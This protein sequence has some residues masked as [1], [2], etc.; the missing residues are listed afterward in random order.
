MINTL[1]GTIK[2]ISDN[3][4][5]LE[6][7]SIGFAIQVP[8]TSLFGIGQPAHLLI[9][10]HWNQENGPAL[11]GFNSSLEK[12]VFLLIT[13]CSGVGPKLGMAILAQLG[14]SEFLEAVQSANEGALSAVSGIGAKKAEQIIVHLKHKVAKL[15]ESGISLGGSATLEQ[16]HNISQV[17]KS[18]NYSR[19]EISAAMNYLNDSYPSNSVAF[20][21]L[22]RHALSFLAKRT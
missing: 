14:A 11:F 2:D 15:V 19:Q 7:G 17:L 13:S 5:T 20:D 6:A 1:S 9:H 10:M 18:L 4:L 3:T 21:Q 22:M 16:R 8:Q 12:T